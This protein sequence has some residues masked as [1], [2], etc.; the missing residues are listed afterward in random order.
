LAVVWLVLGFGCCF[1]LAWFFGGGLGFGLVFGFGFGFCV[2]VLALRLG[3]GFGLGFWFGLLLVWLCV[4]RAP[5]GARVFFLLLVF[6]FLFLPPLFPF[7]CFIRFLCLFYWLVGWFVVCLVGWLVG[8]L[9][10]CLAVVW[11]VLGFGC[12]F[13]LA[14]FF[15]GG[16]GFGLVFGFGF[17]FGFLVLAL[18][19]GFGFGLG[20]WFGLLLVW[21]CVARAPSGARVFF[22]LLV[23]SFLFLPPLFPFC[24]F[25]RFLCLFYWLVGWFVVCLVGWL[26]GWLARCLAVV[27]LVLGFGCCFGLAWFFGGG[28]GFG[29]VFG[30][31]F[32]FGFLVLALRLGFGF[33][34][35]FWFGLLL[36]WLCVARAPS[37]A[38]VFFLLLVFSFLF[39][40]PLFPFCCFIRF[41]CLRGVFVIY[42]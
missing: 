38:R 34:L 18:R 5:S 29:L 21:L 41:L 1:G 26:V 36:V 6:S 12:C 17:G 11:L 7:C 8:W 32:G 31:G 42:N 10:R 25:I 13:G 33:G 14:W 19:L 20:F 4:A 22:L 40:P 28:L 37:G 15:G 3:F 16:L 35:G 30:F 24:C 23:F 27:W 39:L 2:L 9:A